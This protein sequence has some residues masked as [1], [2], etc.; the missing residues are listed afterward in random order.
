MLKRLI[1]ISGVTNNNFETVNT[2]FNRI[3][4]EYVKYCEELI[5]VG[6]GD[7]NFGYKKGNKF[8]LYTYPGYSK[9]NQIKRFYWLFFKSKKTIINTLNE[10]N[11]DRKVDHIQIRLPDILTFFISIHLKKLLN[12]SFYMA[13]DWFLA[14]KFNYPLFAIPAFIL[15]KIQTKLISN[16]IVICTGDSLSE[17]YSKSLSYAYYSSTHEKSFPKNSSRFTN[18]IIYVG[19]LEPRKRVIDLIKA[20]NISDFLKNN[21]TLNIIG[22]GSQKDRLIS[23]VKERNISS[24]FFRGKI[25][26]YN[27]LKKYY[28]ESDLLVLPSLAEGTPRVF[29]EALSNG[30]L[31]SGVRDVSSNNKILKYSNGGFLFNPKD[32]KSI[33]KIIEDLYKCD[34]NELLRLRKNANSYAKNHTISKEVNKMFDFINNNIN[35][36][37]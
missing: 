14:V 16:E 27:I 15:D 17:K 24:I 32:S 4:H 22:S 1:I 9:K 7:K 11:Y 25:N 26:D 5:H 3:L 18:K 29:G 34:K 36:N 31:V 2:G 12:K 13:S 21:I 23:Y 8:S 6:P 19:T 30:C 37:I 28:Y 20:F 33:S 10:L 35:S